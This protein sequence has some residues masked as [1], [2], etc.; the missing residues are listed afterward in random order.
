MSV[1]VVTS[2]TSPMSPSG[3]SIL[4]LQGLSKT[5]PGTKALDDVSLDIPDGE[6]HA[7]VGQN[8][9]GKSTLIKVLAGYHDADSGARILVDG[10][11]LEPSHPG[12]QAYRELARWLVDAKH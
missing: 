3:A 12:A 4:R 2:D 11:T 8:G 10:E 7:L 1:D 6:I 5:F 9:S